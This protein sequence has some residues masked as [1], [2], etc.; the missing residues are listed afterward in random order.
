MS[1]DWSLKDKEGDIHRELSFGISVIKTLR[2]KLIEDLED[3]RED[4]F[5]GRNWK[6]IMKQ[7]IN[8]RFGVE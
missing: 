8:K 2:E 5:S 7:R 4:F 1:D 3:I 6:L